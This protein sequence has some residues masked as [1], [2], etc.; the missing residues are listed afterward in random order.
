MGWDPIPFYSNPF[1]RFNPNS[2][3]Y[4]HTPSRPYVFP[5]EDDIRT[6]WA[7][8]VRVESLKGI[9]IGWDGVVR[10]WDRLQWS[11]KVLG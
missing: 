5:L 7:N 1:Q 6:G 11:G 3:P 2:V 9:E 10:H 8:W 4:H